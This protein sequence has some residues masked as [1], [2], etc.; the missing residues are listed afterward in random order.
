MMLEQSMSSTQLEQLR[1]RINDED[2]LHEAIQRIAQVLSNELPDT[3]KE[4]K[5]DGRRK[6]RG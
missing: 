6:K 4:K 2:Y 5:Y 3:F 1:N